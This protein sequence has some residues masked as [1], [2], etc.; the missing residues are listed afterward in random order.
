MVVCLG[1]ETGRA[2]TFDQV[3]TNSFLGKTGGGS[4][5]DPNPSFD[6]GGV[7]S[8]DSSSDSSNS[9]GGVVGFAFRFG[10]LEAS[11]S[12]CLGCWRGGVGCCR[13]G[14]GGGGPIYGS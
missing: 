1:L 13:G 6:S 10:G 8:A 9:M 5:S 11:G 2:L 12:V 3:V 4:D 7:D 14:G